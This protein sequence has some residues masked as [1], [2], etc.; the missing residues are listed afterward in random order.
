MTKR[1]TGELKRLARENLIG[2]YIP[3]ICAMLTAFFMPIALL[4]PFAPR[5]IAKLSQEWIIPALA[6]FILAVLGQLLVVCAVRIHILLAKKQRLRYKDMYWA[7]F[8]QPDRYLLAALLLA[9]AFILP[10]VP[11]G[12]GIYYLAAW[13]SASGSVAMAS[14]AVVFLAVEIYIAFMLELVYPLY[15]DQPQL[16]VLEGF[17]MSCALMRGNKLRFLQ[18]QLSFFGWFLLGLCSAGIGFL[19]IIPYI[20]QTSANFYLDLT[21]QL[22]QVQQDQDASNELKI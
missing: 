18:L 4:G 7:F 11:A 2:N 6:A 19:W 12:F 22:D 15:I 5:P 21:G 17:R 1:K 9:A 3:V 20:G 14:A 13:D 10:A 16:S 8:N